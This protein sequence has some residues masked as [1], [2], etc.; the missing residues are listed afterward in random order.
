MKLTLIT[1]LVLPLL[2]VFGTA[3]AVHCYWQAD[4]FF[5]NLATE[6]LGILITICY[7]DWI[8]TRHEQQQ[9]TPTDRRINDRLRVLL[10]ATVSSIRSSIGFGTDVL[11]QSALLSND[12]IQMHR[13]VIRVG[14]HVVAPALDKRIAALD[15]RG[16]HLLNK[17]AMR[18]AAATILFVQTF[19]NRMSP[20]QL[21]LLLDLEDALSG[22]MTYYA[23]FPDVIGVP[24]DNLPNPDDLRQPAI[25]KAG[26]ECTVREL[27]KVMS[28]CAAISGNIPDS[29]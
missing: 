11:N 3:V 17:Q 6:L 10:N 4:G 25:Q 24:H 16:W 29:A 20:E 18:S 27:Q 8:L 12:A 23:T 14:E 9:W 7:V 19:Q 15:E 1:P 21:T 2:A 22:S 13:D 28:L 26:I 5:L